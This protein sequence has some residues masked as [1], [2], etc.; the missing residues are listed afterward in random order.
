MANVSFAVFW[1]SPVFQCPNKPQGLHEINRFTESKIDALFVRFGGLEKRLDKVDLRH[2]PVGTVK[3]NDAVVGWINAISTLEDYDRIHCA[4]LEGTCDWILERDEFKT[5]FSTK[6]DVET[7]KFLWIKGPPGSGKTFLTARIIDYLRSHTPLAQFFCHYAHERKR[8]P[9]EVLRSW[10]SQLVQSSH[11]ASATA[12]ETYRGRIT[13]L[14]TESEVWGLFKRLVLQT[15]HF[16]F[17]LDG[18]DECIG[19]EPGSRACSIQNARERF[20]HGICDSLLNTGN[21]AL[22]VSREDL[23][24]SSLIKSSEAHKNC[25]LE[26]TI[27]RTDTNADIKRFASSVIAYKLSNKPQTFR[28][29]LATSACEKC[30]GMFLWVYNL[31]KQLKPR[32]SPQKLR[33]II[34]ETP[35]GLDQAYERILQ[36]IAEHED[37]ERYRAVAILRWVMFAIRPLT[38]QQIAEALLV[39][40]DDKD[41]SR[42]FPLEELP[43]EYDDSFCNEEI[44]R[45]CGPLICLQSSEL[46]KPVKYR[47]IQFVHFSVKEYLSSETI[48]EKF[49]NFGKTFF[50]DKASAH[51]LLAQHCL[52][53]LCYTDFIQTGGSTEHE[54]EEKQNQYGFL[55]YASGYWTKHNQLCG[56]LPLEATRWTNHLFDPSAHKWLSYSEAVGTKVH[57]SFKKF[58]SRFRYAYPSP[59]YSASL[60]GMVPTMEFL[61]TQREARINGIGAPYGSPL[62]AASAMGHLDAVKFLLHHNADINLRGGRWNTPLQ[63]AAARGHKEIVELLLRSNANVHLDGGDWH[64]PLIAAASSSA[65]SHYAVEI[66]R[67]LLEA[68]AVIDNGMK[69]GK[70]ALHVA[71]E[72]CPELVSL[73][74][75]HGADVN[76]TSHHGWTALHYASRQG[77]EAIVEHLL[78]Y[79]ADVK[80]ED[81]KGRTPLHIA[82]K[83][84][85]EKSVQVLLDHGA[86]AHARNRGGIDSDW[87][88]LHYA[89]KNTDINSLEILLSAGA[90]IDRQDA[91]GQT[92]CCH[93]IRYQKNQVIKFLLERG[94]N[95]AIIDGYGRSCFDWSA[96]VNWIDPRPPNLSSKISPKDLTDRQYIQRKYVYSTSAKLKEL[97]AFNVRDKPQYAIWHNQL[98]HQLSQLKH[99]IDA[100]TAFERSSCKIVAGKYSFG[101]DGFECDYSWREFDPTRYRYVCSVCVAIDLCRSCMK[102]YTD[103]GFIQMDERALERCVGHEFIKVPGP[104]WQ[105]LNAGKVNT[106]G[107]TEVEWLDRLMAFCGSEQ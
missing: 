103:N 69:N 53:Y 31:Q 37:K 2:E 58:E 67:L 98:G 82:A 30:E 10:V 101:C 13:D 36:G 71:S 51:K 41:T 78:E 40:I 65:T 85:Q 19:D 60:K 75:Q 25:W 81:A 29:E 83:N 79:G 93:A 63:A 70:K 90:D 24:I 43:N 38:V 35:G 44:L 42:S 22:L 68:G 64:N 7:S 52:R 28:D 6:Q 16:V 96:C 8:Q 33:Q 34:L 45:P 14:A 18:F 32:A 49:P 50:A 55:T 47:T 97:L 59:L 56:D 99:M 27:S 73:L 61:I 106:L 9:L 88:P 4:R 86:D 11:I 46:T 1:I 23:D 26:Y 102:A 100:C 54:F 48:D 104:Q 94:A 76:A 80:S 57:G 77:S 21:K 3:S 62:Q 39:S 12:K 89:T 84:G 72:G 20:L 5:W 105:R 95:P 92:A 107:E 74:L 17:I 87:T 91:T 15:R 66:T